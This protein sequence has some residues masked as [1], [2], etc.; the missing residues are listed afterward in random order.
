VKNVL[1]RLLRRTFGAALAAGLVAGSLG[2]AQAEEFVIHTFERRPLTDVYYSEGIGAGDLNR[3]GHVDVVYG[4]YWFAGPGFTEKHPI[5]TAKPQNR[6]GY[7]DHFFAWVRDFNGDGWNDILTAG[8][9]GTPAFVYENPRAEGHGKNWPKHQV[10]NQVGNESPHFTNL[11]GDAQPELVCTRDGF[12]GYATI[13]PARPFEAWTFHPVSKKIA[14][15]PFGHGLGVG[16]VNGDGRL[17]LLMQHGWFEQPKTLDDARTW[18]LHPAPFAPIG[19]ADMHA[20]DVDG[21]GDNDV[22]TSLAAHDFGLAWYEQVKE[23]DS[24]SF[25]Q[26]LIMGDQPAHNRYGVVF[27]ELHSVNL[28]D[29]DGDGLKDIVTGKTYYSHHKQS[30]MWDAGAVVYWFRLVRKSDG[31]DWVPYKADGDSGIGRQLVVHDINGDGLLDLA[32]GGMK[33]A[34]VLIHHREV[35]DKKRWEDA[36]PKVRHAALKPQTRGRQ[37]AIDAKSGRVAE[38]VEAEGLTVLNTT[39]GKTG[40][41]PMGGFP[42]GKWSGGEQLFWTGARPGDRL[43]L[44]LSV[45]EDGTFDVVTAFT[46]ARDYGIV[47]LALDGAALGEPLD[48]YNYPDV[49]ASGE[50]T[51]G[52]KPLKAGTHRLTLEIKGAN[53]SAVKAYMVGLDY[54]RLAPRRP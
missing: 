16:D 21:D 20:Y 37:A 8:F 10:F 34:N 42:A 31:V 32:A 39:S 47:Q 19:G 17:D 5:Y 26:H 9:P 49:I 44:E 45:P 41:Q 18:T 24:V 28:A 33:G 29:I 7:A 2:L 35:V 54:L 1:P 15:I 46:M 12:Y 13:D 11:V 48:L 50:L 6:E 53:P 30:P 38:A 51:L 40:R 23:G 25:R 27:S 4:P 36:Q 52:S 22:I 3:D 14:P 43:E